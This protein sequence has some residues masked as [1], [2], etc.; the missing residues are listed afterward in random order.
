MPPLC[1]APPVLELSLSFA[2]N[3]CF[4]GETNSDSSGTFS[5]SDIQLYYDASAI[6]DFVSEE[7]SRALMMNKHMAIPILC[8]HQVV[9]AIPPRSTNHSFSA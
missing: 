7:F 3:W 9:Q 2:E 1:F 4:T 5:V 6:D 8:F